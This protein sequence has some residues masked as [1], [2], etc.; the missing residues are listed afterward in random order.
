MIACRRAW[1]VRSNAAKRAVLRQLPTRTQTSR[2]LSPCRLAR[3]TKF[4]VLADDDALLRDRPRPDLKVVRLVEADLQ[5]VDAVTAP[6]AKVD[7]ELERQLV[8]D[9]QLHAVWSTM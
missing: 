3:I 2:P 1:R 9:E 6:S 5:D 4:F 8:V 7:G